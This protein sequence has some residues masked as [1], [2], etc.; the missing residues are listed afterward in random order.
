MPTHSPI[1]GQHKIIVTELITFLYGVMVVLLFVWC[2]ASTGRRQDA[3]PFAPQEV[4]MGIVP[5][6]LTGCVVC[7][8]TLQ[9]P[10]SR[11]HY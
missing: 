8:L 1:R 11:C 9:L 2:V 10:P 4:D 7:N 3:I 6:L 5:S